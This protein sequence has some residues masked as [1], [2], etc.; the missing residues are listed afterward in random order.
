MAKKSKLDSLKQT[1]GKVEKPLTLNQVWGDDGSSRYGTLN[2]DEYM[3]YLN[4]LNKSD[5]QTHAVKIGLVPVD[6][7]VTLVKRLKIEFNKFSSQYK[8]RPVASN[9]SISKSAKDILSEGR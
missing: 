3:V 6:D 1:H 7:R 8:T 4:N 2:V 5:L 9:K